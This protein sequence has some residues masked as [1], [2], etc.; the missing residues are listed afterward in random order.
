M[1]DLS[2]SAATVEEALESYGWKQTPGKPNRFALPTPSG[3]VIIRRQIVSTDWTQYTIRAKATKP[4]EPSLLEANAKLPGPWKFVIDEEKEIAFRADVPRSVLTG[5]Y[6]HDFTLSPTNETRL[7]PLET[8]VDDLSAFAGACR[9]DANGVAKNAFSAYDVAASLDRQA[10][11][12]TAE[13]DGVRITITLPRL[14]KQVF[15]VREE[16]GT[17]LWT[18]LVGLQDW[19][20]ECRQAALSFAEQANHRLPLVRMAL[21]AGEG[22]GPANKLRAEVH[23]GNVRVP[24]VWL[25]AALES[26]RSAVA[27]CARE[28]PALRDCELANVTLAAHAA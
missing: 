4:S 15:V 6:E 1:I 8:W 16:G 2:K 19:S 5:R 24:G 21:I 13:G 25:D 7:N 22:N 11:A 10:W 17:R 9:K 23:L 12:A 3:A 26:L 27:L 20:D 28:L 18:D 14:F